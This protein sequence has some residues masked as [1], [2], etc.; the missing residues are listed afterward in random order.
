MME[1]LSKEIEALYVL[2]SEEVHKADPVGKVLQTVNAEW[3]NVATMHLSYTLGKR[4]RIIAIVVELEAKPTLY[5]IY[6]PCEVNPA[7]VEK[8]MMTTGKV[9]AEMRLVASDLREAVSIVRSIVLT[10]FINQK[11][12]DGNEEERPAG[13]EKAGT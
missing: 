10:E 12:Q 13:G 2:L 4:P 9:P 5:S 7:K 11:A 3:P 6:W 1:G 8:A